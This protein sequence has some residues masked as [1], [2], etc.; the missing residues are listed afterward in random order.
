M[1]KFKDATPAQKKIVSSILKGMLV[2]ANCDANY[3][4]LQ[5]AEDLMIRQSTSNPPPERRRLRLMLVL[6]QNPLIKIKIGTI[7]VRGHLNEQISIPTFFINEINEVFVNKIIAKL[8]KSPIKKPD[9]LDDLIWSHLPDEI[10]KRWDRFSGAMQKHIVECVT[11]DLPKLLAK[12]PDQKQ[13]DIGVTF[14]SPIGLSTP[15]LPV[16]LPP[17]KKSEA[18]APAA[19]GPADSKAAV[20]DVK[21]EVNKVYD[22]LEILAIKERDPSDASRRRHPITHEYFS[23]QDVLP[24]ADAL[25]ELKKRAEKILDDEEAIAAPKAADGG[26]PSLSPKS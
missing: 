24:A 7:K 4:I 19:S 9:D 6:V 2:M 18:D 20:T 8:T 23:L 3:R 13:A 11:A 16:R 21:A 25:I 12:I 22:L 26:M 14:M 1:I 15:S 5:D 17:P 10:T